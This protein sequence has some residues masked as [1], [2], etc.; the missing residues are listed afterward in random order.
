MNVELADGDEMQFVTGDAVDPATAPGQQYCAVVS[1]HPL[2]T[3]SFFPVPAQS[4]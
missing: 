1:V 2:P 4:Y 3:V